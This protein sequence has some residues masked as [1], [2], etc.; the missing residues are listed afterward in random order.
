MRSGLLVFLQFYLQDLQWQSCFNYSYLTNIYDW[1]SLNKAFIIL[2]IVRVIFTSRQSYGWKLS[3]WIRLKIFWSKHE[4]SSDQYSTTFLNALLCFS[5]I[6]LMDWGAGE[7]ISLCLSGTWT[8]SPPPSVLFLPLDL[9]SLPRG[10]S[11]WTFFLELF[12]MITRIFVLVSLKIFWPSFHTRWHCYW[13]QA[14]QHTNHDSNQWKVDIKN[15]FYFVVAL[16]IYGEASLGQCCKA[17][18][19]I[20]SIW[21]FT[22]LNQLTYR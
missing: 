11:E 10:G 2:I 3:T 8:S 21:R 18:Q 15:Q 17:G 14:T 12:P 19:S 5:L 1:I 9:E 22:S 16:I 4:A 20:V 6:L 7:P 13:R